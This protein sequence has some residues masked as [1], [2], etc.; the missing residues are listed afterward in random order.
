MNVEYL[1]KHKVCCL[2]DK[3]LS[4]KEDGAYVGTSGNHSNACYCSTV[5][6]STL[7]A[8]AYCQGV[9]DPNAIQTCV[10]LELARCPNS[11]S[12]RW[13]AFIAN[14]QGF[15]ISINT[16]GLQQ[17]RWNHIPTSFC[18]LQIPY[19][20]SSGNRDSWMGVPLQRLSEC[21]SFM[22]TSS[23]A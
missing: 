6:Y 8:C 16:W 23:M 17:Q 11:H 7:A 14:C 19:H 22:P 20:S 5:F 3:L 1:H 12:R 2:A 4:V 9:A 10:Q 13:G 21:A 15:D 18:I